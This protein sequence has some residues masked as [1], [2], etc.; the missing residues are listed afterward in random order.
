MMEN[1]K[2][3]PY[4]IWLREKQQRDSQ[5]E[6]GDLLG[7]NLH[8]FHTLANNIDGIQPGFYIIGAEANIGKTAL[9]T[10]LTL[11]MLKTNPQIKTLYFSLDDS[12]EVITN[13]F[14]AILSNL[15]INR[16]QRRLEG[17]EKEALNEAYNIIY[18]YAEE[19]R[20]IIKDLSEVYTI[21][22]L[23]S[24]IRLRAARDIFIAI[25]G[26]YNL[27]VEGSRG[28][29]REENIERANHLK[30]IVDTYRLPLVCTAEVRK[31][32]LG[33][34]SRDLTIHDIMESGKFSYN[35]NLILLLGEEEETGVNKRTV[36]FNDE[37]SV[38]LIV[39]YAKNKLS[40]FKGKQKLQ[41]FRKQGRMLE[42]IEG[43]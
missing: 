10:N 6:P 1:N 23:E 4:H 14:L 27:D 25:D 43:G 40:W 30:I 38:T 35:A 19:G 24:E 16:I 21:G 18:D 36:N 22:R 17:D 33:Q 28:G 26:I 42:V 32:S 7:Y 9:L 37:E 31:R 41:F 29:I 11:D 39:N 20:L 34:A 15:P 8:T 2:P 3:K 5:R 12:A 13:R